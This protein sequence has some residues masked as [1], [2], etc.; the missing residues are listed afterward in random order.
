MPFNRAKRRAGV[1]WR[2]LNQAGAFSPFMFGLLAGI[3]VFSSMA[4][5]WAKKDLLKMELERA[6]RAKYE[7]Q[8]IAK[9]LE[10]SILAETAEN[11]DEDLTLERALQH[12]N[13]SYGRTR[14]KQDVL[15]TER[16]GN[17]SFDRHHE[18]IAITA[19]DDTLLRSTINQI[20][21]AD[22]LS[23]LDIGDKEAVVIL[24]TEVLRQRQVDTSHKYMEAMA[25][26][27]YQFFSGQ[28][29]FPTQTEFENLQQ[30][31]KITDVWGQEFD[32]LRKGDFEARLEFTTPWNYTQSV[33]L[34]LKE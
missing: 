11:Y 19:S 26:Q 34:N 17:E 3:A 27:I 22:G 29:R 2:L 9:A 30:Q 13:K 6:N 21:S 8:D 23:R 32:Y 33:D 28:L 31:L 1:P 15:I 10:F 18:R 24:D 5:Q 20:G 16:E 12:T 14:G 4:S 7:A 25:E